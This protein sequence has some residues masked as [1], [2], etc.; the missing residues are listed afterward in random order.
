MKWGHTS[1]RYCLVPVRPR[2]RAELDRRIQRRARVAGGVRVVPMRDP[3]FWRI[4]TVDRIPLDA[5]RFGV[6]IRAGEG[7]TDG[8]LFELLRLH[9]PNLLHAPCRAQVLGRAFADRH[10]RAVLRVR[11]V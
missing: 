1:P 8:D 2:N 5:K 6:L 7:V 3:P 11:E 4:A 9:A 10:D